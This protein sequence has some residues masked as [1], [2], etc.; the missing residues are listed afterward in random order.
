MAGRRRAAAVA[1]ITAGLVAAWASPAFA[2]YSRQA[3]NA[4]NVTE[5]C[6]KYLSLEVAR[7]APEE[8]RPQDV[9]IL[10]FEVAPSTQTLVRLVLNDTVRVRPVHP[11][12][13][14]L[15]PNEEELFQLHGR[16]VLR[17]D[18]GRL[19]PGTRLL[20][21]PI[22]VF[23]PEAQAPPIE[24]TISERCHTPDLEL[25]FVESTDSL[26][27]GRSTTRT[28]GR[29]TSTRRSSV[30]APP[31]SSSGPCPPT[32]RSRFRPPES[33]ARTSCGCSWAASGL[34]RSGLGCWARRP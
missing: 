7:Q 12:L 18:T 13:Q 8:I 9:T 25:S 32:A 19:A 4:V 17:W 15:L 23:G 14:P 31:R 27:P 22:D 20:V 11:F 3:A 16:A 6:P 33:R 5:A 26:L 21:G 28:P 34:T 24:V 1:L 10:A 2:P 29:S 30:S